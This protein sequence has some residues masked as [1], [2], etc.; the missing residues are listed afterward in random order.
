MVF[1]PS[2]QSP[3]DQT[4]FR[5]DGVEGAV[6]AVGLVAG[7]FDGEFGGAAEPVVP[8]GDRVG[9]G[10]RERDL[11]WVQRGQQPVGDRVV[12]GGRG[13]RAAG[14]AWWPVGAAGAL[15][16]R[17][18][19]AVV[20]GA[21]RFAAGSA[22]DDALAQRGSLPRWAG[23]GVGAVAGQGRLVGQVLRPSR[24][25]RR[26]DRAISTGHWARG[27]STSPVCTLP[28]GSTRGADGVAA[29]HVRPGVAGILQHAQ[30]AG[31]SQCA[32]T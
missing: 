5:F 15:V 16:G 4:V 11:V 7:A 18:L 27:R 29:V 6:G 20:V 23:A 30:H 28:S 1:P 31:V 22:G 12:D 14:R 26:G 32:P 17:A 24:C 21:H 19:V 10:Q 13:D 9:G 2:L 3:C 8:V 25:S